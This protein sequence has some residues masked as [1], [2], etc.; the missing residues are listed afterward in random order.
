MSDRQTTD[1]L[2]ERNPR[3]DRNVVSVYE[4]LAGEL[5]KAGV[6]TRTKYSISPPLGGGILSL[7]NH[8]KT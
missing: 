5:E 3:V 2:M 6:D 8:N 1:D 4:K 7:Y